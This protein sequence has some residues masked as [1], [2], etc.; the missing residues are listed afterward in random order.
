MAKV[1]PV[2][3]MKVSDDTEL[4]LTHKGKTY[5]FCSR[6]C[7]EKYAREKG[8]S[9]EV[10]SVEKC[11]SCSSKNN[12]FLKN[13]VF[14]V[15]AVIALLVGMSY[16]MPFLGP[17]RIHL[18]M[19]FKMIWWAVILGLLFGGVIDA[20]V[21]SE[22]ISKVLARK[23]KRTIIYSVLLGFLMSTCSHGILAI[24]IQLYKKGASTPAVV[25]FLLASPWANFTL[26]VMLVSFFGLKALYIIFLTIIVAII[27]GYVF[28][29]L[30][31]KKLVES[32]PNTLEVDDNYSIIRDAR[33]KLSS[34]R[35]SIA[36]LKKDVK[37][38]FVGTLSLSN[39]VL[40]WILI[41]IGLASLSG[42]YIPSHIF[43][44]FMGPSVLGIFVTLALATV[45]EVCSEGTA[46]LAFEIYRQTKALGNSFVFLMGG[47]VTD[48][49]EIGLLWANIG[50]KTAIWLPLV[51]VPQTVIIGIFLNLLIR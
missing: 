19:Y 48:Y 1:D 2:C 49:T 51:T 11:P 43:H 30:E 41:G 50:R 46:P 17:F 24:S 22:Y 37:N 9:L 10:G 14:I 21:P 35:F 40:W 12:S 8:I 27:T 13:K 36:Q 5:Y 31:H 20:F 4:K 44:R 32:N 18:F 39:M 47:V 23:K 26:T 33:N 34:Y 6:H 28:Q 3:G 42:A 7:L 15:S 45:L 38:I 25:S 16:L 29:Y